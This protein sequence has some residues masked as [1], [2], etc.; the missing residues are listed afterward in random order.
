MWC[1]SG[2]LDDNG[3]WFIAWGTGACVLDA[4]G[5]DKDVGL[6]LCEWWCGCVVGLVSSEDDISIFVTKC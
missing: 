6:L 2:G 1:C 4:W 5:R 3:G